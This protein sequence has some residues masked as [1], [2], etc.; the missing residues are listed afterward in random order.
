MAEVN[1][2]DF[3]YV[4]TRQQATPIGTSYY[5]ARFG[6]SGVDMNS[7][8]TYLTGLYSTILK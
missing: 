8:I 6:I 3:Q 4:W 5:K 2:P 1:K 7:R